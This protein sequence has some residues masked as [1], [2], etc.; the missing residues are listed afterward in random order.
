MYLGRALNLCEALLASHSCTEEQTGA[1]G[2]HLQGIFGYSL[3]LCKI[4]F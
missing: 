4:T 2:C 1:A 3:L